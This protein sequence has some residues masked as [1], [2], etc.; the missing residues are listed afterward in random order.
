V[1]ELTSAAA[2]PAGTRLSASGA[3]VAFR[4]VEGRPSAT[5]A[6]RE[7][8]ADA[9]AA[10]DE[11]LAARVRASRRW[12]HDYVRLLRELTA[13]AGDADGA[14]AVAREGLAAIDRRIV[15]DRGGVS[16]PVV[17][18][19]EHVRPAAP[20]A[21]GTVEGTARPVRALRVPYRGTEL[22]GPALRE[23]L[24]RWTAAGV[25]E[26]T[27]AERVSAVSGN[28]DWLSL[29]GRRIAVV[30]AGSEIGPLGP[31]CSW[32]AEI[33]A[34]DV[35]GRPW[36]QI[37]RRAEQG[38]GSVQ[39]PLDG[40]GEPG[41]DLVHQL[42]EARAWLSARAEEGPLVLGMYAYAHGARHL[43]VSAAFDALA[44]PLRSAGAVTLAFLAT[45][46]D[47]FI[48]RA[49]AQQARERY[50]GRGLS[51]LA[52]APAQLLSGGRLFQPA[53]RDGGCVVD[54]LIPQQGPNYAIAKRL[55]RWRGV[56]TAAEHRP[57]SFNVAPATWTR[58]VT[59]NR[60]LAAAYAGARRFGVE[61]F[62]P[63]TTRALMAALLVYDL[64]HEP[65]PRRRAETLFGEGAA[66]GGLWR[67]AYD[68]R[69][70]LGIAALAGLPR[71]VRP[72]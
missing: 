51:R 50:A 61:I 1:A 32:G 9:A 57:V 14:V 36:E 23:Q 49:A 63:E 30:G 67:A 70:V 26:P 34:I 45:P 29:P 48:P 40:R 46:T 39:M 43:L 4:P 5:L 2:D 11:D 55:Q 65:A 15:F 68:P 13:S 21:T 56:V 20:V 69:S 24:A 33:A 19:A 59:S 47:T 38:A 54:A 72:G 7:L 18:A 53:Y 6:G 31:L 41:L 25:I 37:I 64:N 12:R 44:Q 17:V 3:G 22:E 27:V 52:Q 10:I 58:S 28:P 60:V 16:T 8:V 42:P 66:H 35:P 71:L 62:R